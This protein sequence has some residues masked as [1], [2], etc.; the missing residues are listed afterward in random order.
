MKKITALFLSLILSIGFFTEGMAE[1]ELSGLIS[2]T[3]DYIKKTVT[4]PQ[5]ASIGGEW[6]VIGLARSNAEV[7][8]EYYGKYYEN[9]KKYI[10]EKNGVLHTRKYT[11]YSRVILALTAIGKNPENVSGYNLLIPLGDYE[12]T[13]L[14]GING[15]IW[16]LI[17]LDSKNYEI[18][19]NPDAK[20][21][22]TREMYLQYILD[23]QK[24]DGGWALQKSAVQSDVDVTAMALIALSSYTHRDEVRRAT[25][26][27]V[28]MLSNIQQDDGGFR[29]SETSESVAQ[30]ICAMCSLGININDTRFVKNGKTVLDKLL[31][32]RNGEGF[33][34]DNSGNVN[35]M[36][37][38]QA[39]YSLVSLYRFQNDMSDLFDMSRE[40]NFSDIKGHEN[41]TAIK[42]LVKK[43]IVNGKSDSSFDPD[44]TMT[45]AEF[46]TIIV[47]ALGLELKNTS[48][49]SDVREEDW[50]YGYVGGA[51]DCRIINGVGE[52]KFNPHGTITRQESAVMLSRA[53]TYLG[54]AENASSSEANDILS[55]YTDNEKASDWATKS[56]AFCISEG[57]IKEEGS[58]ILPQKEV[59]RAE[60]AQMV[61]NLLERLGRS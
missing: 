3:A 4:D 54:L 57:I 13:I 50:F 33:M 43:G 26:K 34:H 56:L 30:V 16:A 46:A 36:A 40:I 35:Q 2:S 22:A 27:A 42:V 18:P 44:N 9:A 5:V 31:T 61:Y 21:Q 28:S 8:Q 12:K 51:Y 38:E 41:E 24:E 52:E 17:A 11:E 47:K 39:F 15:A 59:K 14:Q 6:A 37:T 58:A 55:V 60:I 1:F 10:N 25:E 49:F 32:Y 53:A 23:L 45:R 7:S 20:I 48:A 29:N 19:Q